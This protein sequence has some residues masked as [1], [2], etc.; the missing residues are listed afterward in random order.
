MFEVKA[1]VRDALCERVVE[2]LEAIDG[3]AGVAVV[4]LN[5]FGHRKDGVMESVERVKLEVDVADAALAD[6]VVDTIVRQGRS[7]EGH[8]GDGRVF[9]SRIDRAVRIR[10]GMEGPDGL[11]PEVAS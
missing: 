2:E 1:Y 4:K 3:V 8:V 5:E 7:G 11:R 9:V 6:A 10:D